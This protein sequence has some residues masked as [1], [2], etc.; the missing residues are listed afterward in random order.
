MAFLIESTS[1]STW[2]SAEPG[3][4]T[5]ALLTVAE[6]AAYLRVSRA[7]LWRWCQEGRVP[8]FKIGH[9]WRIVRSTL[10]QL[11]NT[12]WRTSEDRP[13]GAPEER[14]SMRCDL[15]AHR[16]HLECRRTGHED[17]KR[18]PGF[19]GGTEM[20]GN[21]TA[22][23]RL[24]AII[25]MAAVLLLPGGTVWGAD[26]DVLGTPQHT[27]AP[28]HA[29]NPGTTLYMKWASTVSHNGAAVTICD[30]NW[31]SLN[32]THGYI[33]DQSYQRIY[34]WKNADNTG[35]IAPTSTEFDTIY[36]GTTKGY[37]QG[38]NGGKLLEGHVTCGPPPSCGD[39][40]GNAPGEQCDPPGPTALPV[41]S[42]SSRHWACRSISGVRSM[43]AI[44]PR[45][46]R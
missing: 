38:A 10:E 27:W 6:A 16:K 22:W 29:S 32:G 26:G 4:G 33:A 25:L 41:A 46:R 31:T 30:S 34:I 14:T 7:T 37:L 44:Q 35:V 21:P 23:R 17:K 2:V 18:P 36:N 24:G 3:N 42:G 11:T 40:A 43:Q 8:G 9:E 39:G 5:E 28:G 1:V 13:L 19:L 45:P 12:D 15:R 20:R